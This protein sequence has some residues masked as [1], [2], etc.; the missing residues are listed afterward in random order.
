MATCSVG[1]RR[2]TVAFVFIAAAGAALLLAGCQPPVSVLS[3][4]V[5]IAGSGAPAAGIPV[6]V[7]TNTDDT[8]VAR[9]LTGSGGDYSF[10]SATVVDGTYRIRFGD[11]DW[12]HGAGDWDHATHVTLTAASPTS[13]NDTL[14]G[15]AVTGIVTASA[16]PIPGARVQ[17]YEATAGLTNNNTPVAT[18]TTLSNGRYTFGAL[19]A[20]SYTVRVTASGYTTRYYDRAGA[21]R[22]STFT[23][24]AGQTTSG[25][26]VTLAAESTITGTLTNGT[27]GVAGI[28]VV[29]DDATTGQR[30]LLTTATTASDG[31]FTL[32]GLDNVPY[33]LEFIDSK[34]QFR[35]QVFGSMSLDPLAGTRV[36]PPS[37]GNTNIGTIGLVP[38]DCDHGFSGAD[39]SGANFADANLTNCDL[40]FTNLRA[41]DLAGA[42][43]AGANLNSANLTSADLTGADLTGVVLDANLTDATLTGAHLTGADLGGAI[44]TNVTSGGITGSPALASAWSITNGYL[45]GPFAN[46]TGANF[47]HAGLVGADF[48]GV[49]LT[50]AT[51]TG[52]T[53]TGDNLGGANLAGADLTGATLTGV[54]SG[55]IT[56]VPAALP[57]NWSLVS[58]FLVGPGAD[59]AE[60]S[61]SFADLA[62]ADLAGANLKSADLTSADLTGADLTGADL[63]GAKLLDATLAGADLSGADLGGAILTDVSS[64]GI[65]GTP[66]LPVF[67]SLTNGYLIGPFANLS[68][69]DLG[70]VDLTGVDFV[71]VNLT[72]ATLTGATLTGD[73]LRGDNLGGAD[74]TSATLTG[75]MSGSITG[76][77]AALPTNWSLVSSFLVGPGAD[78]ADTNLSFADLAGADLAGAN[79]N[80]ADLTGA[81]LTGADLSGVVLDAKLTDAT[82]TGADLS[83]ADLGGAILTNVSS[84]GITGAPALASGWSI[85]NGYLIG[86]FANLTGANFDHADLVGA[87]FLGVNLTA[88]KLTGADL[89]GDNLGGA[90]LNGADLTDATLTGVDLTGADLTGATLT[91]VVSGSITGVPAALPTGWSIVNGNLVGPT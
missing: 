5:Q 35:T 30:L 36:T 52:A 59:L 21:P 20:G 76:V 47:A 33:T 53:F 69:A 80:S 65:T 90:N 68:G 85:K 62:G 83:G 75:V 41:A 44:L 67:W 26:D 48:L 29:A 16:Q 40:S 57:T 56:G 60:T 2:S 12:W 4:H 10:S 24:T 27:T 63:T 91:G 74:L 1:L 11:T 64:G 54:R 55:S 32:H 45:I 38:K 14:P 61:L 3:G 18:T 66:V 15:G 37:A 84:G 71:G 78:L 87:D 6:A 50:D 88:A 89:T 72:N 46:D 8:L 49:N 82:L 7:Y 43:L 31:T 9:T 25:I 79:V 42:D 34:G 19:P 22:D 70:H 17:A 73:N 28:I 86:P 58:S 77:P 51:L 39:L 13:I 23:V 81:N